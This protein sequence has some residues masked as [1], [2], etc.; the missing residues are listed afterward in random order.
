MA[1]DDLSDDGVSPP[2]WQ[3][4]S[5]REPE[6]DKEIEGNEPDEIPPSDPDSYVGLKEAENNGQWLQCIGKSVEKLPSY[7]GFLET[8][9]SGMRVALPCYPVRFHTVGR[10][11]SLF[12]G[13][14][15][16][17]HV[18]RCHRHLPWSAKA[19]A[20]RAYSNGGLYA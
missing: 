20:C 6:D 10:E 17:A 16:R 9:L 1:M 3:S 5:E 15:G 11:A 13:V 7:D 14:I 4:G 19:G 2:E 8:Q 12:L 18:V